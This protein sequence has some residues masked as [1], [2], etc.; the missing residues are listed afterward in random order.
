MNS[1]IFRLSP[2]VLVFSA[3]CLWVR[4]VSA[5]SY[6]FLTDVPNYEWH[7]GC[8]GTASGNLMGY[9]DRHGLPDFYTG[10]VAGG[11]APLD[12][13]GTNTGIR[14]MWASQKGLD[15][16]PSDS[17]GHLDDYWV[18]YESP[19]PDTYVTAGRSEHTPD[20]IGDFIGLNQQKWI[21]QA[22]ECDGNI[23]G[24]SFVYWDKT[25]NG[26][27]NFTPTASSGPPP[28]DIQSGLREWTRYRGYDADV[29]TQLT[30]FNPERTTTN[31]FTFEDLKAQINAGFPVLC[32]IQPANQFSREVGAI[33]NANPPIHGVMAYGYIE[34][35]DLGI[36]K[37][38]LIRTSWASSYEV[39][40][41]WSSED[42]VDLYPVRGVICFHPKPKI[43][44]FTR[45]DGSI[46]ITWDGPSS[47]LHDELANTT[48]TVHRYQLEKATTS[49]FS[50]FTPIGPETTERTVTVPDTGNATV[51]YRLKLVQP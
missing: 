20:C 3:C 23:D 27:T 50:A 11:V 24:Y 25:G 6:V 37:G 32:Y 31:G 33:K 14:S 8:F 18:E 40:Q 7:A 48:A 10:L 38:V 12:S 42:W 34:Q 30:D 28:K 4:F 19:A 49:D 26:R 1:L 44:N 13:F 39:I 17:F 36:T 29:F 47:Q 21:N 9:W 43:R 5:E 51:F 22:G 41:G 2:K 46:T 16:R 45:S 35:P 15:G